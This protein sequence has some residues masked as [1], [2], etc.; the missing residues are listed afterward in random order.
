MSIPHDPQAEQD[1]VAAMLLTDEARRVGLETC[2]GADL[3][4]PETRQAFN[5]IDSLVAQGQSVDATTVAAG[6]GVNRGS[7]LQWQA[8]L[9]ASW[10][11]RTYARIVADCAAMRRT[12]DLA[13]EL[14]AAAR[15]GEVERVDALLGEGPER[16]ASPAGS[17]EPGVEASELAAVDY[18][19]RW[20]IRDLLE[21]G[22]RVMFV[23][24]EGQ[25]KS[26]LLRQFAVSCASGMHPWNRT[27][28]PRLRVLLL[29]LEN[30]DAQVARSLQG[31]LSAAGDRYAR[32]LWVKSRRQ[33]MDLCSRRDVRWLD[34]LLGH[35]EPDLL[36]FGPLY[37]AYRGS[38][39]R[40]K[41]SEESAE[42]CAAALDELR[43]KHDCA[44]LMESHAGHGAGNDRDGWRPTGS[45][46][47]LRWPEFGIGLKP[48]SVK[49]R[50]VDLVRWRGDR[51]TGREW[52]AALIEGNP[53]HWPW[54]P[55]NER[56]A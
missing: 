41:S 39:K 46:L 6:S 35:H 31:L 11:V 51:E 30:S 23:G 10:H 20:L 38:D 15:A 1:L 5:A 27:P 40:S 12:L 28:M 21:R 2:A 49:P 4:V 3:Y 17:V 13:A 7:L 29:D 55:M 9:P 8:S 48:V 52:P 42:Q 22:D 34:A 33:G 36:V 18:Q 50:Q 45:S 54:L 43:V 44:L 53:G 14:D 16:V 25:G 26:T 19:H 37:K 47:W 24:G 32:S 56:A